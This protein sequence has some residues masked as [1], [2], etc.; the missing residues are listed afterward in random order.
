MFDENGDLTNKAAIVGGI[1]LIALW[2]LVG[3]I[4]YNS[5]F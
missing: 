3:T 1:I 4:E 5:L 2:L